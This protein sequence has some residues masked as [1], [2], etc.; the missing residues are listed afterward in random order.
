MF[1]DSEWN[2][3]EQVIVD[4]F[5]KEL[6]VMRSEIEGLLEAA[7]TMFNQSVFE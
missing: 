7:Y 4:K 6:F 5:A 3:E 2:S 1:A